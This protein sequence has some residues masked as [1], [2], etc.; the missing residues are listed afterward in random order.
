MKF[1]IP[2]ML[3]VVSFLLALSSAQARESVL[4]AIPSDAIS[5]AVVHNLADTSRSV[6]ELAKLVQAPT[7]DLLSLAKAAS[8]LQKGIDEQGDIA[9]VLTSVDPV[10]KVVILVPV[11]NF[12]EFF[13]ALGVAEPASGAVEIQLGGASKYVGRKGIYAALS[14]AA[15]HDALDQLLASTSSLAA[16]ASLATWLDTNKVSAVVTARGVQQLAP[17]L[18]SG[19]RMAQAQVHQL[20]GAQ[21]QSAADALDMYVDLLAA[22]EPEVAQLGIGLRIDSAKTVDLVKRVQFTPGGACALW[23]TNIKPA[24][25]NV[26][27][28]LPAE[29]FVVAMGGAT[30]Q[31]VTAKFMRFSLQAMQQNPAIKLTPEQVEKYMQLTTETMRNARYMRMLL[32]VAEPGT[33]LYGNTLMVMTVDDS[34]SYLDQ[35]EKSLAAIREFNQE[36]KIPL[37][38]EPT[39]QRI[40]LGEMEVLE[41]SMAMPDMAPLTPPGAP[42]MQKTMQ[43]LVGPDGKLKLYAAPADDHTVVMAYTSLEHLKAAI[44]FYKSKQPG[45]SSEAGVAKVAAMLPAGS[46]MIAYVSLSGATNVARQF[47]ANVPG[48]HTTVIPE[49]PDSPPIGMAAKVTT[50]GIEGHFVVTAETLGT[51]GDIVAKIR[52]AAPGPAA[53]PQ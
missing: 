6:S 4:T 14:T 8:G 41:V 25:E 36:T 20:P 13:A 46:Q 5:F 1:V 47:A 11:A 33:G 45:L 16:D 34:K 9:L 12:A 52:G 28:G 27:A 40:K 48:A 18:V 50:E 3:S 38:P 29:P 21:G 53:P 17:K 35:Y 7:P 39:S 10:P 37:M 15:D 19:I 42:D 22:A 24:E 26:L 43:M 23:A 49:F 30:P 32:G 51:I 44:D 2:R 31:G